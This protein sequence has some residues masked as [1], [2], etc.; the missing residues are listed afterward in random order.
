M[1]DPAVV[2]GHIARYDRHQSVCSVMIG[3]IYWCRDKGPLTFAGD[4][5]RTKILVEKPGIYPDLKVLNRPNWPSGE[6]R[7]MYVTVWGPIRTDIGTDMVLPVHLTLRLF[8]A[9][10]LKAHIR[11]MSWLLP[12]FCLFALQKGKKV[13]S[14]KSRH[15]DYA[16]EW[17]GST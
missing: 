10:A 12:F 17:F 1:L 5:I 13:K 15:M 4:P 8:A 9:E 16:W 11:K 7:N 3:S 2:I 6:D 14:P